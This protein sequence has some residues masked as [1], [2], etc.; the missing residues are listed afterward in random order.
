MSKITMLAMALSIA[1]LSFML[2]QVPEKHRL[3]GAGTGLLVGG[4]YGALL[5]RR[6]DEL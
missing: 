1:G 6:H 3:V 4:T 2:G 5:R